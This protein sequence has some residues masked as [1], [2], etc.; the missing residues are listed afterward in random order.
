MG[1]SGQSSRAELN[2]AGQR[3]FCHSDS[4][5]STRAMPS[6]PT[7]C[8][9]FLNKKL[10]CSEN[11]PGL[12]LRTSGP[13][14]CRLSLDR[15][16]SDPRRPGRAVGGAGRFTYGAAERLHQPART[17][18]SPPP[19]PFQG[20]MLQGWRPAPLGCPAQWGRGFGWCRRGTWPIKVGGHV[21]RQ[22][23]GRGC[24]VGR[25]F[26]SGGEGGLRVGKWVPCGAATDADGGSGRLEDGDR[27]PCEAPD[28]RGT[29]LSCSLC[30]RP[31]P[32]AASPG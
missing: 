30:F 22:G 14:W 2:A 10:R 1:A 15:F 12:R 32:D 31:V 9:L 21:R 19:C 5:D 25:I 27:V 11:K 28:R 24:L 3:T 20:A 16:S 23:Q 18:P 13:V 8:L 29:I 7:L 17:A 4:T 26:S 6:I